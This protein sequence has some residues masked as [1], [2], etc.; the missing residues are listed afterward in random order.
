MSSERERESER[1]QGAK[2]EQERKLRQTSLNDF[3]LAP[4]VIETPCALSPFPLS[5]HAE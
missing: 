5:D 4:V 2:S 1:N 3:T